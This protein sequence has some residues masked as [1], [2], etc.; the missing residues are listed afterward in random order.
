MWR[1]VK[2]E[3]YKVFHNRWLWAA[4]IIGVAITSVNLIENIQRMEAYGY[5]VGDI[6][7]NYRGLSLFVHWIAI[8]GTS[9]GF[10]IFYFVWPILAAMPFGWSYRQE[11]RNGVY[12]QMVFRNGRR[13]YYIAKF[14][15]V[16]VSGG[17]A[18][19]LPVL[20]NLLANA[21]I[22]P[23][24]LP[25]VNDSISMVFDGNFL[26]NVYYT[27]PWLYSL[28][29][30]CVEFFWGGS[31]ACLCFLVGAKPHLQ[32]IVVLLPFV[33]LVALDV[34]CAFM[35]NYR[36]CNLTLSPLNLAAASSANQNPEWLI[37]AEICMM[38]MISFVGGY[39]QVVKHELV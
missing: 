8:A 9:M 30:C 21:M 19:A 32:V 24:L 2:I 20:F 39:W 29:W 28:V 1:S 10:R 11:R 14:F 16:F 37:I 4:I 5:K 6:G 36:Q 23:A 22:C 33:S 25:H 7:G 13:N 27:S 34:L 17:L 31:V 26:S 12:D 35:L 3:L 38:T 15:T 18:V